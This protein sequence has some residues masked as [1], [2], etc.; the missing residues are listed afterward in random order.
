MVVSQVVMLRQHTESALGLPAAQIKTRR[1]EEFKA[2]KQDR[3]RR[4]AEQKAERKA[5]RDIQRKKEY[6][7]ICRE[8]IEERII[9]MQE[10]I[11]KV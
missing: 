3:E 5:E 2:L 1:E 4:I 8:K 9:E 11:E 7:R 10:A 6:V